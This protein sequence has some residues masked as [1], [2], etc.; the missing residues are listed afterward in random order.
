MMTGARLSALGLAVVLF[1][2]PFG[3]LDVVAMAQL[4]VETQQSESRQTAGA[5]AGTSTPAPRGFDRY[6]FGAAA[7]NLLWIPFKIGTCG[8]SAGAGALAF[9][10]TLGFARGWTES[11]FDEGCVRDW[12]LTG[13]DFRPMASPSAS[14]GQ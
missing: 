14:E 10:F 5:P 6:D 7:A 1:L 8:I 12:L 9:I 2:T 11:A 3:R 13:E 4:P